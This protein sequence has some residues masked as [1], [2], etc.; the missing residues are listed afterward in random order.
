[1]GC[2]LAVIYLTLVFLLD[3]R[4]KDEEDLHAI[5]DFPVLAQIPA[6]SAEAERKS[7]YGNNAYAKSGYGYAASTEKGTEA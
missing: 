1:M 3:V 7:G 6:F 4:I 2:V 5:F